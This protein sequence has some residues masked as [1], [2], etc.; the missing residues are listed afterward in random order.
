[1][2]ISRIKL[3]RFTAFEELDFKPSPGVKIRSKSEF[4]NKKCNRKEPESYPPRGNPKFSY[5]CLCNDRMKG[6]TY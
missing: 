2:A 1:M 4:S 3:K 6:D 5:S